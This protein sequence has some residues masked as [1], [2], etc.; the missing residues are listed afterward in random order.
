MDSSLLE[1]FSQF[2]FSGCNLHRL[3][4]VGNSRKSPLGPQC[5]HE[6]FYGGGRLME[7]KIT[8]I[9]GEN[10]QDYGNRPLNTG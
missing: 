6:H 4:Q 2:Y 5:D 3:I 7:V 8:V 10:F 9:K 1:R